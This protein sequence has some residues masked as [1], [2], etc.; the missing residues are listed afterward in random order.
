MSRQP[1]APAGPGPRK[2]RPKAP[3]LTVIVPAHRAAG[4]LSE[5]LKALAASDLAP[6]A[7]ELVVVNDGAD[8]ETCAVARRYADVVLRLP[9]KPRG[10]S[11]ARNRGAEVARGQVLVFLDADVCPHEDALRR[12]A[13]LFSENPDVAAAFGSYDDR[14][15]ASGV[16]SRYRNLLHHYVHQCSPGDAETFWA[17]LGAIRRSVF[18]EV[19]MYDE[20]HFSRP[21]IEDIEL[22]RRIRR[23]GN[24][25][26]L[27]AEI[28]GCHLKRWTFRDVLATDL[29]H[30][31]V[32]WT[33]LILHEGRNRGARAL[34]LSP[35]HRWCSGLAALTALGLVAGLAWWKA[36]LLIAA[37]L[38]AAG[39]TALNLPFYAVV[40]RCCGWRTALASIPLHLLFYLANGVSAITGWIAYSLFGPP[41]PPPDVA[42]FEEIGVETWPP[43]PARPKESLWYRDG[44]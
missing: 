30:R 36:W 3:Y 6:D 5:S 35:H 40:R 13:D 12:F 44:E 2:Q 11:Y 28:Q 31:G 27:A 8:D 24:R 16:V 29:K 42:A 39:V 38:A 20:W 33:R 26:V 25:I 14:P 9:G 37:A 18:H 1:D 34:N 19:G 4:A 23:H 43:V 21:Q 15:R 22:G 17:G 7:W 32:P 10:P 41:Q